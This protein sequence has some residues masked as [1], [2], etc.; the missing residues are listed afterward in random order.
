MSSIARK[1]VSVSPSKAPKKSLPALV[2][3]ALGRLRDTM[4]ASPDGGCVGEEE[5]EMWGKEV[6]LRMV[7]RNVFIVYCRFLTALLVGCSRIS[8]R[9]V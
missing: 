6:V 2:T 1:S 7:R 4:K 5:F 3:S 9:E 8:G